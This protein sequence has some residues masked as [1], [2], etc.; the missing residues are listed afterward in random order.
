MGMTDKQFKSFL[1]EMI[2]NQE[3]IRKD[4]EKNDPEEAMIKVDNLIERL[5]KGIED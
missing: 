2:H 4:L 1:R 5:Q 3:E